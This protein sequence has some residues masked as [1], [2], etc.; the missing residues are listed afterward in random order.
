MNLDN[1]SW[2][3]GFVPPAITS[4]TYDAFTGELA[5][6]GTDLLPVTGA[7]N[8]I[9][10]NK[11]TIKGEGGATYTL[12]DTQNGKISRTTSFKL[13]QRANDRAMVNTLRNKNSIS[14]TK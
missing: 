3:E 13:T 7:N 12:K 11:F 8:D 4:S 2:C 1:F 14:M 10:A 5:V 9:I 6:T